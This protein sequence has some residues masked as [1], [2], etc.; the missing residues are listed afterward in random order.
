MSVGRSANPITNSVSGVKDTITF[1]RSPT[2]Q[3]GTFT[4]TITAIGADGNSAT[5]NY[6]LT[7][8]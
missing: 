2:A 5:S 7:I 6:M 8:S 1:Y 4:V 3:K